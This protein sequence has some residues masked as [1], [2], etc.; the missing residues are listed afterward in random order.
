MYRMLLWY[1]IHCD[2]RSSSSYLCGYVFHLQ[3][4]SCLYIDDGTARRWFLILFGVISDVTVN[5]DVGYQMYDDVDDSY[6]LW[7]HQFILEM[8]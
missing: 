4:S 3:Q 6:N 1:T 5:K 2:Y 8:N 7:Y